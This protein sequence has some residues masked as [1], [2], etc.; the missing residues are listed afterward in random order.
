[1]RFIEIHSATLL[2]WRRMTATDD[3]QGGT[4]IRIDDPNVLKID[5]SPAI[6]GLGGWNR[7]YVT[8]AGEGRR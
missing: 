8:Y 6:Y 7:Y 1:M 5:G 4:V 2:A 3:P